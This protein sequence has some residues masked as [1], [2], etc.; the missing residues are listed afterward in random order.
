MK[1]VT[2]APINAG[3]PNIAESSSRHDAP[4]KFA[5]IVGP[6]GGQFSILIDNG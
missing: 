5:R 2:T 6:S 1:G 4:A 3:Q